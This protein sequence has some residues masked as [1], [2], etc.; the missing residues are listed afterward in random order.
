MQLGLFCL[1]PCIRKN[2][3]GESL[4][5]TVASD[6]T[7]KRK[8]WRMVWRCWLAISFRWQEAGKGTTYNYAKE[9]FLGPQNLDT[10]GQIRQ[11][12]RR[13]QSRSDNRFSSGPTLTTEAGEA[14]IQHADRQVPS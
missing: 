10:M 13:E 6:L 5:Y 9:P 12:G 7:A 1:L 11:R 2:D 3:S 4:I 14:A 8:R